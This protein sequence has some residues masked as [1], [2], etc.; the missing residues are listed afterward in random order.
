MKNQYMPFRVDV[1]TFDCNQITSFLNKK[2]VLYFLK[3]KIILTVKK[4]IIKFYVKKINDKNI[5]DG[6][7]TRNL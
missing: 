5:L 6:T 3:H 7:W 2:W 4:I 1:N